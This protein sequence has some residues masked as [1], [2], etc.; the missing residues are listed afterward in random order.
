MIAVVERHRVDLRAPSG[1]VHSHLGDLHR[2]QDTA[3][4]FSVELGQEHTVAAPDV[5]RAGRR[6][7]GAGAQPD[8]M[9]G[10]P[11]GTEGA[12]PGVTEPVL[13]LP[14]VGAGVEGLQLVVAVHRTRPVYAASPEMI[15][16]AGP[17]RRPLVA[18]ALPP[19]AVTVPPRSVN[20]PPAFSKMNFR[21]D[22]SQG[23]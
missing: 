18:I 3:E 11:A 12:P 14:G 22:M 5:Q 20:R 15:A 17:W 4:P 23:G 2:M 7:A 8:D 1:D 13:T 6:D 21:S 9:V 16:R 19:P 10:L